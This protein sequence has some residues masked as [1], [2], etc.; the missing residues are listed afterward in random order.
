MAVPS[1]QAPR[2]TASFE[3]GGSAPLNRDGWLRAARRTDAELWA[4]AQMNRPTAALTASPLPDAAAPTPS[5]TRARTVLEG[6]P[7]SAPSNAAIGAWAPPR[8]SSSEQR[9][10][11]K[12]EGWVLADSRTRPDRLPP[13]GKRR[14]TRYLPPDSR[15]VSW[16]AARGSMCSSRERVCART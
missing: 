15:F 5:A 7:T 16:I 11:L 8:E 14:V 13:E 10:Q 2:R 3:G 1:L 4:L 6:S 9:A 12:A